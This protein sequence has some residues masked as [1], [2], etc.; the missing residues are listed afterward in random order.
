MSHDLIPLH[1]PSAHPTLPHL[2]IILDGGTLREGEPNAGRT[3][4]VC[5]PQLATMGGWR[6]LR[7]NQHFQHLI[8]E[9]EW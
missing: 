2:R 9:P 3:T 5:G 1:V 4:A 8:K 7:T 6:I